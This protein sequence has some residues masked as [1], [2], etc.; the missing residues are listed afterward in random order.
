MNS[1]GIFLRGATIA[2][3]RNKA[4][5]YEATMADLG[6]K[7][8]CYKCSS[9]FYDLKKPRAVCPKCGADQADAPAVPVAAAPAPVVPQKRAP[10]MVDPP[11]EELPEEP[12]EDAEAAPAT[13]DDVDVD[14]DA[15]SGEDL[16]EPAGEDSF[17]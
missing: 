1:S 2:K 11:A 12:L 5:T 9:K 14:D 17:D 16:D 7:H 6:R 13:E 10:R 8:T 3:E 15:P 4:L